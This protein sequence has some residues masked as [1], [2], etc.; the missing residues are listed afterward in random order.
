M[1]ASLHS[2]I[3]LTPRQRAVR[4]VRDII[5]RGVVKP[6]DRLP[7]EE[8][9][10]EKFA[11]SRATLRLALSHLER[12]GVIKRQKNCGCV[13]TTKSR[14]GGGIMASTIALVS[15]LRVASG[16]NIFSGL[17]E[18]VHSGALDMAGRHAMNLLA[19]HSMDESTIDNLIASHPRGVVLTSWKHQTD[20]AV[21]AR[22]AEAGIPIVVYGAG[23]QLAKVDRVASDHVQGAYDLARQLL[24]A[25]KKRILRLWTGPADA[26]WIRDHN[27]GCERAFS[28]AAVEVVPPVY[29]TDLPPRQPETKEN[30]DR[31]MR[32]FAGHLVEHLGGKQPVDAIM[33]A[34]DCEV[35]PVA[36][37]C[38][39]AGADGIA[40]TGYD[41]QW[42]DAF[43]RQWEPA[44]PFATV[45]KNNHRIGEELVRLMVERITGQL[46][47]TPQARRVEQ[48]MIII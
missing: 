17:S 40:I 24:V 48:R 37:A 46:P 25:G 1:T 16:P 32:F 22:L 7:A 34:T 3:R 5:D 36:A 43:E 47:E 29:V 38:R 9:L 45:D 39:L 31:R 6:G 26:S 44:V 30:F 42:H 19:T 12:E 18:A 35:F 8:A 2:P 28:E 23:P 27:I 33:L 41:N 4:G 11:V 13:V 15:D 20:V 10:A 14:S 21:L